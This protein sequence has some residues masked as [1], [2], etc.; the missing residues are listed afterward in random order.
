[1]NRKDLA[2]LIEEEIK[3]LHGSLVNECVS[4]A[5]KRHMMLA[6]NDAVRMLREIDGIEG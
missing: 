5:D 4:P 2:T 1:M 6:L 3:A